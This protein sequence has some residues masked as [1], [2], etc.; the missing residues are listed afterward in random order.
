MF[1]MYR[2]PTMDIRIKF[3]LFVSSEL[4]NYP[5]NAATAL[6]SMS[7]KM[8]AGGAPTLLPRRT[9]IPTTKYPVGHFVLC[10]SVV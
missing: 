2:T 6:T 9:V 10:S 4:E 1:N 8:A 5:G 3:K 7:G